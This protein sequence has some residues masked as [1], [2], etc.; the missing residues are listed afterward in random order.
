M[1]LSVLDLSPISSGA[2]AGETLWR[3]VE[4]AEHAEAC[5]YVR[6]WLAEHHNAA[7]VASSAPEIL[8]GQIAARTK[9]LRVGAGGI[10]LPNHSPLKVAELFRVLS[11]MFPG[12]IDLGLGRAAGTDP[13]TGRELRRGK[14]LTDPDEVAAELAV[15]EAYLGQDAAYRPPFAGTTVAIPRTT[16]RPQLW[17]LGSSDYSGA[18]AAKK[19]L[20]FAFARHMNPDDAAHELTKYRASF[21]SVHGSKPHAIVSVAVVCAESEEQARRLASSAELGWIRFAQGR[22]DEPLPSVEEALAHEDD[23][24]DAAIRGMFRSRMVVGDPSQVERRLTAIAQEC[25]ADEIMLLTHVHDHQARKRS[26]RLVADAFGHATQ[27]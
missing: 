20:G 16:E 12:R 4:L 8:I 22:R 3:S 15:L 25:E 10:M 23:E 26:Y 14:P 5:G 1:L 6:Y 2:T 24:H 19:G 27:D 13:R 17:L 7:S 18:L 9:H 11:A 21:Q